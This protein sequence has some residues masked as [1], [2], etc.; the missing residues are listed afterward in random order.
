M[1]QLYEGPLAQLYDRAVPDWPGEIEF[2]RTL[3]E[4]NVSR[5]DS[6]LELACGTGRVAIKMAQAGFRVVGVDLSE[7]MLSMARHKSTGLLHLSWE[8]ADMR[9]FRLNRTFALALLP[10]YSFQL[11]LS[12][13]DQIS[14]LE[15]IWHH[16][17]PDTRLVLHLEPHDPDWLTS[18]PVDGYTPFEPSGETMHPSTGNRV[19][20]SYA[21]SY[22][23]AER[24]VSVIIRYE[25]LGP[26]GDILGCVERE[27]LR[28]HCT[29][30]FQLEQMLSSV[31]FDVEEQRDAFA[32]SPTGDCSEEM[33]WIARKRT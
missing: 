21:W 24:Y 11:L 14:C 25:T 6:I 29:R 1:S 8:H 17:I 23:P 27:P 2:Y 7:E 15:S 4:K 12:E 26:A 10:A 32:S 22:A 18:L 3:A 9:T 31:G 20:V 30:P 13:E 5:D 19:R 16:L 33:I 28:M